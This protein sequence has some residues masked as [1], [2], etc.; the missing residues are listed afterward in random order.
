[1]PERNIQ[2]DVRKDNND[3]EYNGRREISDGREREKTH[4]ERREEVEERER[5]K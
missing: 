4:G 3:G 2:K 1:M 5:R